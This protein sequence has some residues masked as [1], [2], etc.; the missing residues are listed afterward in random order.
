MATLWPPAIDPNVRFQDPAFGV[1][2][3][4]DAGDMWRM[5]CGSSNDLELT[6]TIADADDTSAHV[7]W[8]ATYTFGATKRLVKTLL[9]PQSLLPTTK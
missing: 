7:D 9:Q 5:L 8:L 6:Y 1:L 4:K 2:H 3:G